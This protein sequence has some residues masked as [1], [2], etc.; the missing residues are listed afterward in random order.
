MKKFS[1]F[2][3]SMVNRKKVNL[4]IFKIYEKTQFE[5]LSIVFDHSKKD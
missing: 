5:F 4:T 2:L 3:L 1:R